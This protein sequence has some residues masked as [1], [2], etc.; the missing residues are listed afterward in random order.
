M[1]DRRS[2][3]LASVLILLV[4]GCRGAEPEAQE[5]GTLR[6]GAALSL[7]GQL[8]REG[9]LTRDGYEYCKQVIN[10]EGGVQ[11]GDQTYQLDIVYQ[12]DRSTPD[13]AAQ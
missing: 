5:G 1:S 2:L 13:V 3:L 8:S 4:A 7:T 11:V 12:D 10:G 6:F 9:E